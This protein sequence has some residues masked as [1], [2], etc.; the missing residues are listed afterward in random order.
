[1]EFPEKIVEI[2]EKQLSPT[3]DQEEDYLIKTQ[4]QSASHYISI[5]DKGLNSSTKADG[6]SNSDNQP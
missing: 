2:S 4:V 6:Q 5:E 1:V 3:D